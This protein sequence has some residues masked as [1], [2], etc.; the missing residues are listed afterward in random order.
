M[1]FLRTPAAKHIVLG[2]APYVLLLLVM[3]KVGY[4][5]W[6]ETVL[7][8]LPIFVVAVLAMAWRQNFGGHLLLVSAELGLLAE[9]GIHLMNGPKPNLSGAFCNT[10]ILMAGTLAAVVVQFAINRRRR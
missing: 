1:K 8:Y 2:A 10:A 7:I 9:Y 3:G 6:R 5:G 4:L